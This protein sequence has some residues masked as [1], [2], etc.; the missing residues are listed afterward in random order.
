MVEYQEDKSNV[1]VTNVLMK[2]RKV[3]EVGENITLSRQQ[4]AILKKWRK[5]KGCGG[6]R[7]EFYTK[8]KPEN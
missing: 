3:L 8:F 7:E 5:N 6:V 1:K 2:V 4:V